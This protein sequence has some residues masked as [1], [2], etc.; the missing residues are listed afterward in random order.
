M[1]EKMKLT[2]CAGPHHMHFINDYNQNFLVYIFNWL[3]VACWPVEKITQTE[4]V[5]DL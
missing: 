1:I 4:K 2:E 3:I 5:S